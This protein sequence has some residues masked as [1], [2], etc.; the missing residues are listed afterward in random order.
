MKIT[1][2]IILS[3]LTFLSQLLLSHSTRC[4]PQDKKVLLKI[5]KAFNNPYHLASWNPDTDCCQ[6]YVVDCDRK[7][8]R[9]T[10]FHLF[11]AN[12]SGQIPPAIADLPYLESLTFHKITNLTGTIPPALARLTNLKRLSISWT[13]IS[14]PIPSFLSQL[15]NLTF[16]DLSFNNFS[17][18]IPQ[19]LGELRNL[20]GLRLD[21]NKLTG[22]IPDSFGDLSPSLQ[23]LYLSHN[24]LSGSIPRA[25]G[26]LNFTSVLFDRNRLEGDISFLFGKNKTVQNVDFSR[27]MLRF[28]LSN[29]EFPDSLS[30]LD[31][32][33]NRIYGSLPE[34]LA[35][36]ENLYLNVSYNRL[37]GQIPV[38]GRLQELDYS[39]YFHN[40]CLCG[41][42]LPNCK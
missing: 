6:W 36:L 8:N 23:Y 29:V 20:S 7:T 18:A 4:N 30:T 17:G 27:N 24:Q 15:K 12:I 16:L 11:A 42:P 32:N 5:K 22:P 37:C 26:D 1:L 10:N 28:D 41:A 13:N 40:R 38:G 31:L 14:G 19:T 33:H 35:K 3:I 2:L 34:G 25:W 39:S 21:R 9:I